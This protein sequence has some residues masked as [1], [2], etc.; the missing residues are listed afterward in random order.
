MRD[1]LKDPARRAASSRAAALALQ[2]SVS[3][4]LIAILFFAIDW[5]GLR[6]A[7]S[8]LSVGGVAGV[9]LLSFLA[10]SALAW[11][12]QAM[13]ATVGVRDSIARSWRNVFAGLFLSNLLPGTLGSDGLRI[14]LMTRACGSAPLAIGAIAYERTVQL[15]IYVVLIVLASLW[16]MTWLSPLLRAAI[17]AGGGS[18]I[19]LLLLILKWLSGRKIAPAPLGADLLERT[20]KFLGAMMAET[21]R[22]QLRLRRHRRAHLQFMLS[23]LCNVILIVAMVTLALHGIGRPAALPVIVFA[24][25]AALI[26]TGV[27]ISFGG[28]GVFEAV[29]VL[30]L[31]LGGV[32]AADALLTA[33]V[34]RAASVLVSLLGLPGAVIL[35]RDWR[36]ARQL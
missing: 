5:R 6:Q 26:S 15:A 13:L 22:M 11:R 31:G 35:W 14:L 30:I 27:P 10:Q 9:V 18:C 4:G 23:S 3:L 2:L 8:A 34:V 20:L 29:L 28:I 17:V 16:P 19:L 21:G 33:L 7:A 1:V 36:L 12:W 32:P 24:L 25:G